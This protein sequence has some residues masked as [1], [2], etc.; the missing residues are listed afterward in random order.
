VV[1][2]GEA[3]DALDNGAITLPAQPRLW[4]L[5]EGEVG[6]GERAHADS[7]QD[8]RQGARHQHP[9]AHGGNDQQGG[10]GT[11]SV[12]AGARARTDY[13]RGGAASGVPD[14]AGHEILRINQET[15]SL[16]QPVAGP[17]ADA[18]PTKASRSDRNFTRD[19][20]DFNPSDVIEELGEVVLADSIQQGVD[21]WIEGDEETATDR[22]GKAVAH[23]YGQG[24]EEVLERIGRVVDIEDPVTGRVRLKRPD[25]ID[26]LEARSTRTNRKRV[27]QIESRTPAKLRGPHAAHPLRDY[28]DEDR[29]CPIS[30]LLMPAGETRCSSCGGELG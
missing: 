9:G 6:Q 4:R 7:R 14:R 24:A 17:S 29:F 16:E 21:A 1:T 5:E 18:R 2:F 25:E 28:L 13:R 10:A 22:L 19:E 12:A 23:A 11:A 3:L 30:G 8:R 26:I 20:D 15:V 27:G